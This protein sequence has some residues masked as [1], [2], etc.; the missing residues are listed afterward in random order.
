MF[1]L[2][3]PFPKLCD[4]VTNGELRTA[5]GDTEMEAFVEYMYSG[6]V[7]KVSGCYNFCDRHQF[8]RALHHIYRSSRAEEFVFW[9]NTN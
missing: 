4:N 7:Y 3:A 2:R 1:M 5:C 9:D 8:V 6:S